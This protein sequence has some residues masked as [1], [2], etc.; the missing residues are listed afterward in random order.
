MVVPFILGEK[1]Y[2]AALASRASSMKQVKFVPFE[3][4][5]CLGKYYVN[6]F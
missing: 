5:R 2:K 6:T 1:L 4:E 3:A